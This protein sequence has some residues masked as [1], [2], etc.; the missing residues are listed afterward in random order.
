MWTTARRDCFFRQAMQAPWPSCCGAF[1]TRQNNVAGSEA[2]HGRRRYGAFRRARE[3]TSIWIIT[4]CPHDLGEFKTMSATL[5]SSLVE[6]LERDGI[7]LIP[8]LLSPGQLDGMRQAFA[9]RLK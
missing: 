8:D 7:A 1:T 5:T 9:N 2:R 3:S 6:S 4:V